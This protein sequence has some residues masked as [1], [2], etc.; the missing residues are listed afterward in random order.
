MHHPASLR[1]G[2]A[3][4]PIGDID[5]GAGVTG[6]ERVDQLRPVD[7]DLFDMLR[8]RRAD[9]VA[10]V[11]AVARNSRGRGPVGRD[12]P[13]RAGFTATTFATVSL[14]PPRVSFCH[15]PAAPTASVLERAEH[16]AVHLLA[17][18]Q[19]Q[20]ATIFATSGIDP[21]ASYPYWESGPFGLPL[22]TGVLGV[23]LCQVV[24]RIS[25]GDQSMV[26]AEPLA[27]SAGIDGDPLLHHHG[28]YATVTSV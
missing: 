7:H 28:G 6:R 5:A 20:A 21:F 22:L 3:T 25:V 4:L 24:H 16:V 12:A 27:L 23:L 10:V 13:S 15:D 14:N 9:P 8:Q 18:N 1:P 17:A 11:T 19:T 2:H 26:I